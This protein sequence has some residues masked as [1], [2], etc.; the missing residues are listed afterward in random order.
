MQTLVQSLPPAEIGTAQQE[1]PVA[2]LNT[3]HTLQ[4]T[5]EEVDVLYHALCDY[6]KSNDASEITSED[7]LLP[8]FVRELLDTLEAPLKDVL[9][10]QR[11]RQRNYALTQKIKQVEISALNN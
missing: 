5:T 7:Q 10:A 1:I 11:L 6:I 3:L 8:Y 9:E 2:T 4:L